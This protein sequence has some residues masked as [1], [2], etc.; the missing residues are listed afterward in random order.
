MS[1]AHTDG[2]ENQ[3]LDDADLQRR[4]ESEGREYQRLWDRE[5]RVSQTTYQVLPGSRLLIHAWERWR[6][7]RLAAKLRGLTLS[8]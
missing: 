4:E 8:K 1:R 7:T 6:K 3:H 2:N 5:R